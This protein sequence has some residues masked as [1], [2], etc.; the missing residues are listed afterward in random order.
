M[1]NLVSEA[2][3]QEDED[4]AGAS[5]QKPNPSLVDHL[6]RRQIDSTS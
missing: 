5:I 4:E 6:I 2:H 3:V 1:S